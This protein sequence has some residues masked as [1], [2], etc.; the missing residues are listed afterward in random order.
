MVVGMMRW[1][2][3]LPGVDSLKEKRMVVRSLKDRIR[4]RF[5]ISVAETALQDQ[6][7]RAQIAVA[8]VA[9]DPGHAGEVLDS[10]DRM[11]SREARALV[12]ERRRELY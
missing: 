3:S 8:L 10:V 12:L 2:L 4:H 6:L 7:T 1:D 9:T 5:K 11:V